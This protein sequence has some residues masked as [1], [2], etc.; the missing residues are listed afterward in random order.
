MPRS[1]CTP[2]KNR[3]ELPC[4]RT[5]CFTVGVVGGV[6]GL[7][8]IRRHIDSVTCGGARGD[9]CPPKVIETQPIE[10][11]LAPPSSESRC[12]DFRS[13]R[14]RGSRNCSS[15]QSNGRRMRGVGQYWTKRHDMRWKQANGSNDTGWL[16]IADSSLL[17]V[18]IL[19]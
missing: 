3:L 4:Y 14:A 7:A 11:H 16:V 19:S 8:T 9:R 10:S 17:L 6:V 12:T 5:L 1:H 18:V 13:W 2:L 15:T